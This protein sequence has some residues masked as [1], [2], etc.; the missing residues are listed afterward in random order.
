MVH[1]DNIE[2]LIGQEIALPV[3][4][5]RQ[6]EDF[7]SASL[8]EYLEKHNLTSEADAY[9]FLHPI[10]RESTQVPEGGCNH[11]MWVI[12]GELMWAKHDRKIDE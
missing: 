12:D 1:N 10:S 4:L 9:R 8:W 7:I 2:T 6:L 3:C 11:R 5:P